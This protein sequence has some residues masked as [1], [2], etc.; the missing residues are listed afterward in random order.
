M[1]WWIQPSPTTTQSGTYPL[2]RPTLTHGQTARTDESRRLLY[3]PRV[4][5]PDPPATGDEQTSKSDLPLPCS[6]SPA[7]SSHPRPSLASLLSVRWQQ[8]S[9][10]PPAPSRQAPVRSSLVAG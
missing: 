6:P 1:P 8:A 10:R 7:T 9:T 3:S 4:A 2:R 5:T